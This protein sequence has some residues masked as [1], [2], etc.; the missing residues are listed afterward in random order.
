MPTAAAPID[1]AVCPLRSQV[2]Q[3]LG[4]CSYVFKH[5][6]AVTNLGLQLVASFARGMRATALEAQHFL[7]LVVPDSAK[8]SI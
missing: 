3:Q 2:V 7:P 8:P 1:S 4:V 5:A 6:V